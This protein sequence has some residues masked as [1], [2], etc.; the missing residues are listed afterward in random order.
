M[1]ELIRLN[2]EVPQRQAAPQKRTTSMTPANTAAILGNGGMG[3]FE[4]ARMNRLLGDWIASSRS[5]DQ[6]LFG[7]N[8]KLRARARKLELNNPIMAKFLQMLVQ[9]VAGPAGI[10]MQAKIK[11]A[12]GTALSKKINTRIESA[13]QRFCHVGNC[14]AD[15]TMSMIDLQHMAIRNCGREGENVLKINYDRSYPFGIAFQLID[16]DQLDDTMMQLNGQNEIRM[17]VEVNQYRR[18]IAYYL[19]DGHPFDFLSPGRRR[20]RTSA[21]QV[22]HTFLRR[23]PA[24]TRGYCWA[25]PSL[26]AMNMLEKYM[27]A[28][29]VAARVSAA[30]FAVIEQDGG[31]GYTGE[32]EDAQGADTNADN[33]LRMSGDPGTAPVLDQGQKLN[34]IDP[35]HPTQAFEPFMKGALRLLASGML[36]AYP[37]LANDLENVNFS[38]IRAGLLDERD[39]WRILQRWFIDHFMWPVYIAWVR[40]ALLTD[41]SDLNLSPDQYM[42]IVWKAR[43]WDWVDPQKDAAA[44]VLKLQNG[45]GTYAAVLAEQGMDFEETI[46]ERAREEEYIRSKGIKLGT[47]IHGVADTAEDDAKD[48]DLAG[49]NTNSDSQNSG[50]SGKNA[51]KE[52]GESS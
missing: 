27:E 35:K 50:K 43:G 38:S 26:W 12:A 5:A 25:A 39:S 52:A 16:N 46:D 36:V 41:L 20:V 13:W 7:D 32:D 18:P 30:K 9:N 31:D 44:T 3:G 11:N 14:T 51:K 10:L 33:T 40:M 28:E 29:V 15:G 34:F 37:N 6:D 23:R 2:L 47:D 4:A 21:D 48:Q 1:A 8:R 22:I 49:D 24:Q 42:Q 19:W 17:G 45:L